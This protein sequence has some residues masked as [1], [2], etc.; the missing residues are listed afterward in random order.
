[1]PEDRLILVAD[2]DPNFRDTIAEAL[3]KASF[4]TIQAENGRQALEL[5][6]ENK[7]DLLILDIAMPEMD[8]DEVC[9]VIRQ[10]DSTPVIFLSA[11]D[12]EGDRIR[13]FELGADDYVTKSGAFSAREL[14]ARVR[15]LLRR[16]TEDWSTT[17]PRDLGLGPL[18][19]DL[20]QYK[21]YWNEKHVPLSTVEFNIVQILAVGSSRAFTRNEIMDRAYM[22]P[23]HEVTER[24]IDSHV[25]GIRRKF[26]EAGAENIIET[27]RGRGYM[28]APIGKKQ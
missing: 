19:L 14:V 2:D 1:M 9:R 20:D 27:V 24:T 6:R 23:T 4:R 21:A 7:P 12:E 28:L 5:F 8:G 11:L 18:R 10:T 13:G 22:E 15:A 26:L 16:V 25:R 3:N 17:K